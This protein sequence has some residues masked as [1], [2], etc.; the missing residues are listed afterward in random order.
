[1]QLVFVRN[2]YT[3]SLQVRY[4][5]HNSQMKER[6]T[7]VKSKNILAFFRKYMISDYILEKVIFELEINTN[8][9]TIDMST[10]R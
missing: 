6:K 5:G 3:V 7:T 4:F 8:R 2:L 9:L 1:M 10:L